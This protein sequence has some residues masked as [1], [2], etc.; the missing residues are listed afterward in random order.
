MTTKNPFGDFEVG[1][2]MLEIAFMFLIYWIL[3]DY[4]IIFVM[5]HEE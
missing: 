1:N 5:L 4:V 2:F 3:L